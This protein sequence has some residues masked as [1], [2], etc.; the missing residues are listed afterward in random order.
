[1]GRRKRMTIYPT[2][3]LKLRRTTRCQCKGH[4]GSRKLSFRDEQAAIMKAI[5]RGWD[6]YD[7]YRCLRGHGWHLTHAKWDT[8]K[9]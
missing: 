6:Q 1:M 9:E 2:P 3:R 5:K 7:V 4:S 8:D